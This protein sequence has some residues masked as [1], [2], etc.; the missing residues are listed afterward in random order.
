MVL[1]EERSRVVPNNHVDFSGALPVLPSIG[2]MPLSFCRKPS[3]CSKMFLTRERGL[4]WIESKIVILLQ[5]WYVVISA[6]YS[7]VLYWESSL[8]LLCLKLERHLY[9]PCL[10]IPSASFDFSD[11]MNDGYHIQ[12]MKSLHLN[13]FARE[14]LRSLAY[15]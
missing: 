9:I 10:Q 3:T 12:S 14:R 7:P 6:V 1:Q 15:S 13:S 8:T 2:D 4:V 5:H 11:E